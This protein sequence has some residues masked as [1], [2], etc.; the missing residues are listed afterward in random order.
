MI[1]SEQRKRIL[2][3]MHQAA[4]TIKPQAGPVESREEMED[5][6][7]EIIAYHIEFAKLAIAARYD[8]DA[9]GRVL[10]FGIP[11]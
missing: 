8:D 2:D 1:T 7:E 5:F 10:L 9:T 3:M 4:T 11:V 6:G